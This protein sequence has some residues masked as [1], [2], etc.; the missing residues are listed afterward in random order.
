M[1]TKYYDEFGNEFAGPY[2]VGTFLG[3]DITSH[4]DESTARQAA[5]QAC[6]A[7]DHT[8]TVY[9]P[10]LGSL[11]ARKVAVYKW[12]GDAPSEV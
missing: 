8:V 4:P 3:D 10:R 11:Q 6:T 12:G 2:G 7:D 1:S 9:G 5:V